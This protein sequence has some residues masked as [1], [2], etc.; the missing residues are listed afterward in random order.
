MWKTHFMR[1]EL[2]FHLLP[3]ID[4]G[5]HDL[6]EAVALARL[7]VADGTR[8][9][10]A[11]P[12]VRDLLRA[13]ALG[14][15]PARVRQVQ[16]ALDSAGVPLTV[17]TGAELA[18]PDLECLSDADLDAIAHGPSGRRWVLIEAPLFGDAHGFLDAT[19]EL[20]ARGFGTV[21]GHPERSAELM[22]IPGALSHERAE[23]ALA[24]VNASSLTGRHDRG[25]RRWGLELVRSGQ[26]DLIAS[27]AHRVTRPPQLTAAVA[28]LADAG[29]PRP[30]RAALVELPGMLLEHGIAPLAH[31]A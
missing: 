31:A 9:V 17:Q 11:T 6:D 20:R 18:H 16:A 2:H 8:V 28:A 19:A 10:T 1:T 29:V 21:I 12:H 23:G 14:E 4:D 26:A 25:A 30:V 7:A 5:P 27:D 3:A 22:A 13:G 15:L 24:Q